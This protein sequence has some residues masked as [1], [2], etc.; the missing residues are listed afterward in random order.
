[1]TVSWDGAELIGLAAKLDESTRSVPR[2][3]RDVIKSGG[4]RVAKAA[5]RFAPKASGDM[6]DSIKST[7]VGNATM[8]EAEIGPTAFYGRFLEHG[9][10][11][12]APRPFLGPALD[13]VSPSIADGIAKAAEGMLDD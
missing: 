8:S 11:K 7:M 12:M 3:V 13:E 6:A 1:M 9:T 4:E 10:A 2:A 5:Q